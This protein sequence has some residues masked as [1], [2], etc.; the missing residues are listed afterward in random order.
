MRGFFGTSSDDYGM[1]LEFYGRALEVLEWGRKIWKDVPSDDRGVIFED[2]F[3]RG[4]KRLYLGALTS[5]CSAVQHSY[6]L[7]HG[8]YCF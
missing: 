6:L 1:V 5:V 7:N 3:V 4:I 2:S 8:S